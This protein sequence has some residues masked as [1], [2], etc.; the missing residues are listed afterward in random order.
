ME[1]VANIESVLEEVGIPSFDNEMEPE[2]IRA[3]RK[4]VVATGPKMTLG[5]YKKAQFKRSRK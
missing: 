5:G 2:P 3:T 1:Q 4:E